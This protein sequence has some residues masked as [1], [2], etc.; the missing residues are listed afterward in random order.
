VA[1]VTA[2]ATFE[3]PASGPPFAGL[4]ATTDIGV[5][6]AGPF[7]NPNYMGTF[8]VAV[9]VAIA[10]VWTAVSS[11]LGRLLLVAVAVLCLV[12]MVQAQSRGAFLA[13]FAGIAAIVWLRSRP[14]AVAIVGVGLIGAVLIYPAFVEWR[15]TNLRGDVT[16]A[17]YVA[18][19]ESD[20]ARL[21]ATLAG[22]AMF[23][24]EPIV[25]VGFGEFVEKSVT[26]S[27]LDTGINAHNWYVN[28]LAEQGITGGLL[29]L[30]ATLA[31]AN[32]LRRRRGAARLVGIGVF[33]TLVVGFL[34]LEGPTSFQLVAVPSMFLIAALV[35]DWDPG[36]AARSGIGDVA[37]SR[38]S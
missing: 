16:D 18:M 23:L 10:G 26:V 13:G 35:S 37:A 15:L 21:N 32:E 3:N 1:T 33:T 8:A 9:L 4:L 36:R 5:R 30:G 28:V 11:S 7:V 31:F 2:I 12:A 14:L 27:G 24:S 19:T 38:G 25:G 17:G 34:F 22:P 6:A 20:D 29:W